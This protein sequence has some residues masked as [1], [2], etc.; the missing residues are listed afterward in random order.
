MTTALPTAFGFLLVVFRC[1]GLFMTAPVLGMKGVPARI[2]LGAA[3]AVSVAAFMGAGAPAYAAWDQGHVMIIAALSEALVGLSAGLIATLSIEAATGAGHLMGISMGLGMGS[4]I[5]PIN[6]Q[7]SSASSQLMTFLAL[8]FAVA[9]GIH[10]E[11][12]AW[13]CRSIIELPPGVPADL[14]DL[15]L[16]VITQATGALALAV[17]LAFPVL[18]AV[19]I[20]HMSLGLLGRVAPQMGLSNVGFAVALVAGM[21]AM[22]FVAPAAASVAAEAA[23]SALVVH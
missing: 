13:L 5:D 17:R 12:V 2:R 16:R 20:G 9:L 22:Y 11:A 18:S 15:A 1:G 8:G 3:F 10:R 23:H 6:G 4:L 14:N 7:E 21:G 19:T